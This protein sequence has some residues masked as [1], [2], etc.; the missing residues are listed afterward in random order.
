ML[1][2][3]QFVTAVTLDFF[4]SNQVNNIEFEDFTSYPN[5]LPEEQEDEVRTITLEH[6]LELSSYQDVVTLTIF[7]RGHHND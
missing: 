3:N 7:L 1:I 2:C 5:P 6:F 4:K